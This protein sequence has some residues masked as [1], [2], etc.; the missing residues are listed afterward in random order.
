MGSQSGSTSVF[1]EAAT[2]VGE[3]LVHNS[4]GLVYGGSDAGLMGTVAQ[5]VKKGGGYVVG[6]MPGG[7]LIPGEKRYNDGIDEFVETA[8]MSERK[9][10]MFETASCIVALPGGPGTLEE[11]S[12][13][14]SWK[15]IGQHKKPIVLVNV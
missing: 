1:S 15:R 8:G 7:G 9:S 10:R 4:L 13:V 3:V 14:V 2:K 11:L 12:E 6:V 5:T